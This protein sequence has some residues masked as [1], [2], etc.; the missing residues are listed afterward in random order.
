[1][2]WRKGL[3]MKHFLGFLI[4][5]FPMCLPASAEIKGCYIRT[6]DAAVLKRHPQQAVTKVV[7]RYGIPPNDQEG[8]VDDVSFY[9][10]GS[11][12]IQF[13][14][15]ACTGRKNKLTCKLTDSGDGSVGGRGNFVLTEIK[16]GVTLSPTTDL[17][18]AAFDGAKPVTLKVKTNPEHKTFTLKKVN[19][20]LESCGG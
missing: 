9:F 18:M 7:V 1:M 6:Y 20:D 13:S 8:F 14:S 2:M 15:Y 12:E 5:V 17:V 16:G 11:T 3:A 19:V 10:R 4:L